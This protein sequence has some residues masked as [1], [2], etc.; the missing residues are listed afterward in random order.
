MLAIWFKGEEAGRGRITN[1][2]CGRR[3]ITDWSRLGEKK[4]ENEE[5]RKDKRT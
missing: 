4:Y 5:G 3:K 1:Q 2:K